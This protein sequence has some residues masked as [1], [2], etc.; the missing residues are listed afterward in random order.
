MLV[1]REFSLI[2]RA[3]TRKNITKVCPWLKSLSRYLGYLLYVY[4]DRKK[5]KLNEKKRTE[6]SASVRLSL[7]T[8]LIPSGLPCNKTPVWRGVKTQIPWFAVWR[9][10]KRPSHGK[11]K[12]ADSCWQTTK[13]WQTRAFT[14]QTRV[15]SQHTVTC[16]DIVVNT[17]LWGEKSNF[18]KNDMMKNRSP[19][20]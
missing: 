13:S 14:R 12:F 19:S 4:D 15:K 3:V 20:P 6:A 1:Q 16:M 2:S 10:V 7:A 18:F 8:A 11:L 5:Q 17:K 9:T